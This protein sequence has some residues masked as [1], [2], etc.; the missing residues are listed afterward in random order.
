M[1][2]YSDLETDK[3]KSLINW[4]A[5]DTA[6]HKMADEMSVRFVDDKTA[7][8]MELLKDTESTTT[9]KTNDDDVIDVDDI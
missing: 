8:Y 9:I 4:S 2:V 1:E 3:L 6:E 5:F 7:E